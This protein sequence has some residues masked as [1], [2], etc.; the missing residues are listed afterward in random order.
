MCAESCPSNS[1]FMSLFLEFLDLR[2]VNG[3]DCAGRLEVFYNG[4]WGSVCSNHMSQLTA[5]TACKHLNCGDSGEIDKDFKYGRGSGPTW[6]DHIDCNKQHSSLWH[7]QSDPWDPQSCDN[8]AEETHIS[9]TGNYKCICTGPPKH[10][11]TCACICG[12]C[13]TYNMFNC[14]PVY[15]IFS[16]MKMAQ[17]FLSN[18]CCKLVN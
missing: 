18:S 5:I 9:C 10:T 16:F 15:I 8:R 6:L 11:E 17:I 1:N 13:S 12:H 3:N 4:T 2:L 14:F 7:C